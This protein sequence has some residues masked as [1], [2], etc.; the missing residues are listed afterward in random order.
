[1]LLLLL[2]LF[3]STMHK[4]GSLHK[5]AGKQIR[6]FIPCLAQSRLPT[7]PP[8]GK[9]TG[10][11]GSSL[12]EQVNSI[13]SGLEQHSVKL[14]AIR[15]PY[16]HWTSSSGMK[17]HP[18]LLHLQ[19]T[20]TS[21]VQEAR[22]VYLVGLFK[23]TNLSS[24]SSQVRSQMSSNTLYYWECAWESMVELGNRLPGKDTRCQ[25]WEPEFNP[26]KLTHKRQE[27]TAEELSFDF[28][29]HATAHVHKTQR[30]SLCSPDYP[31]THYYGD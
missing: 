24:Y 21:A 12:Q 7:N 19:H 17:N 8:E 30:I 4:S 28:Y 3:S 6:K 26:W 22:E 18:G 10:N 15:N 1:M 11:N 23:V 5:T 25:D 16:V 9:H 13:I 31:E 2:Q 14:D 20:T 27:M 29:T